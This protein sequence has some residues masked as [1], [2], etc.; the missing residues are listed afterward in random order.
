MNRPF[1]YVDRYGDAS[2]P[3]PD[4]DTMCKGPCEGTGVYPVSID[5]PMLTDH[6]ES[7]VARI[8]ASAPGQNSDGWYFVTCP[9][10]NGTG[11]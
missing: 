8:E 3:R 6:E 5:N 4:P 10:C 1:E 11:K 9:T 7:E 2:A